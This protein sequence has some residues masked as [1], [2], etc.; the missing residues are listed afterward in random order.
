MDY[1]YIFLLS[2][3]NFLFAD[4]VQFGGELY[5]DGKTARNMGMGGYSVSFS[6]SSNPARLMHTSQSSSIYF[7][8]KNKFAGLSSVT[9][10]SY[11]YTNLIKGIEYPIYISFINKLSAVGNH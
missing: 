4:Y 8:H 7:S 5:M 2:I 11:T 3:I 1:K 6:S 10:F 9:T